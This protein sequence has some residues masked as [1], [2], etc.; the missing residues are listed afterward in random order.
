MSTISVSIFSLFAFCAM[1]GTKMS[2]TEIATKLN[3]I[4]VKSLKLM[5]L[6]GLDS[7]IILDLA[8]K[9]ITVSSL[10][11]AWHAREQKPGI[12]SSF[13]FGKDSYKRFDEMKSLLLRYNTS[14]IVVDDGEVIEIADLPDRSLTQDIFLEG[15][16]RDQKFAYDTL[17]APELVMGRLAIMKSFA[18]LFIHDFFYQLGIKGILSSSVPDLPTEEQEKKIF[19]DLKKFAPNIVTIEVQSRNIAEAEDFIVGKE[20]FLLRH[21]FQLKKSVKLGT[22]VCVELPPWWSD[23][24]IKAFAKRVAEVWNA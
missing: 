20:N 11:P 14:C 16:V 19:Q 23:N 17:H 8:H 24:L 15:G 13:L 9:G 7:K 10:E 3:G 21:L 12:L 1:S 4:G 22:P 5:P 2:A 18:K 6:R